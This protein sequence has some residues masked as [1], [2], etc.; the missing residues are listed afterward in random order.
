MFR[1]SARPLWT[2][3]RLEW[4]PGSNERVRDPKRLP[5]EGS[6]DVHPAP[7]QGITALSSK[8]VSTKG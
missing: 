5:D 7:S 3:T 6:I 4:S 8:D 1:W 2:H